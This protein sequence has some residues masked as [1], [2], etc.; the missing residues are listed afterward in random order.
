[1]GLG[2]RVATELTELKGGQVANSDA[3]RTPAT[4]PI[5][6]AAVYRRLQSD[7]KSAR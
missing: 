4:A 7:V 5:D 6:F 3:E 1:M 2:V